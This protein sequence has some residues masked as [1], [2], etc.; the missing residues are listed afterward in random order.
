MRVA[1]AAWIIVAH[2]LDAVTLMWY[3]V[4]QVFIGG[5]AR[6]QNQLVCARVYNTT[7]QHEKDELDG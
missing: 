6:I 3:Q 5:R 1:L 7:V 4:K 2:S